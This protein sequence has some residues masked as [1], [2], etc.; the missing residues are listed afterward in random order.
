MVITLYP[1]QAAE[2]VEK[3]VTIPVERALV[4]V[5]RVLVQRSITSFGLSQVIVTFE[6]DV[7]IYFARQQVAE[8]LRDAEVPDGV[9]PTLGP[10][11]TPVGQVYQYTLE[12][13]HHSP[14]RAAQLAGLGG[15]EAPDARRRASPTSSASA[16]SRRS[17]TCSPTRCG[18][19][20]SGLTLKD[21]IDAV[22]DL[23][24]R[25]LGR[26]PAARRERVR[27]ARRAAI[28]ESPADIEKTVDQGAERHAGPGAQR[29]ARWSRATRRGAARWRAATPIDSIEG[30]I[31]LAPRREPE[32]GAR[33]ASTRRSSAS[34]ATSCRRACASSP[35][36]DRTRLVDTTLHTVSHNML[37]GA[38]LVT[39][40]LWLFLRALS[41]SL[42]GRGD[43]AARAADRLRRPLLRGGAGQSAVD[44]G[45]RL[46]HPARRRGHPRR[47]RLPPS[48][49][50]E[51]A[52]AGGGAAR[53]RRARP[54]RWCGRSLFSMSIIVAA[55][56]PIFT[57]E[58]VEGRIFRPVALTYA[59]ALGGALLFTL[60]AVPALTAV[61]LKQPEGRG[62][63]ARVPRLAARALPDARCASRCATRSRRR[64][65]GFVDSRRSR[66]CS[67]RSSAP[68]SCREM[69]E[70]DIHITVTMP[71]AV[72]LERGAEVLREMRADAAAAS[73]R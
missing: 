26:L 59:F 11:D 48:R 45:D 17:G 10:N 63:R 55:M 67:S 28:C 72:S 65:A 31:L 33:R 52:A 20:R 25:H 62:G 1:G 9:T 68:S 3:Q 24:R 58:R 6:D 32:G 54:R 43:D 40:V 18:C 69:N 35:F 27:G 13:D 64:V 19:A 39:L 15:L 44:G 16:A 2:E 41:G 7:D 53:R 30:T 12:S 21:L 8:R 71:S 23:E 60:T 50:S 51:Q 37:E 73:P 57:L 66:S 29:R 49:A 61:L 38:A 36:Y 5:P 70:G 14:E 34:T 4:G 56:L 46:R 22:A 47:E 42:R